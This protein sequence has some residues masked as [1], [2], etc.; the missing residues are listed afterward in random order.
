M[1]AEAAVRRDLAELGKRA[2]E[3]ARSSR[4]AAALILAR[5]L[6]DPKS[7]PTACSLCAHELNA[8]MS[9]LEA[10]APPVKRNDELDTLRSRRQARRAAG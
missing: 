5:R 6:D 10:L 8:L 2:P 4:A 1:K 9:R 3:L 7:T